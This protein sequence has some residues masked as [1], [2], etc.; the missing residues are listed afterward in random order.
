MPLVGNMGH[1]LWEVRSKLKGGT[2]ARVLFFMA[3]NS[4]ILVHGFIKKTQKTP[5]GELE[6]AKKRKQQFER[7]DK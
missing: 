3:S 7:D 2:I 4:M 5:Q 6:L 1:G